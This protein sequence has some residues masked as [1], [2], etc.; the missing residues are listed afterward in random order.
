VTVGAMNAGTKGNVIPDKAE[1]LLSV[2]TIDPDVRK[3]ML[4]DIERVVCAEAQA[5]GA[6]TAP[7]IDY[8]ES[9]PVVINEVA[10]SERTRA[11][12]ASV[13]GKGFVVNPGLVTGSEDVGILGTAAG[14][15]TVYWL[16]GGADPALFSEVKGPED[17]ARIAR[18]QPSNHSPRYAPVEDPTIQIGVDTLVAA[19]QEWLDR[20]V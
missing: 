9:A 4:E 2:R 1:L 6:T 10:A 17:L 5:S 3:K 19:A 7:T 12:L 20:P 8:L 14:A 11:A 15:P 16:L 18:A 13:V